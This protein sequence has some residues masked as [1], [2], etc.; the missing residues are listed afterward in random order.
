VDDSEFVAD[1]TV[2]DGTV[3]VPGA[4]FVKAWRLRNSGTCTW[5]TGYQFYDT[6]SGSPGTRISAPQSINIP[7]EVA[8]GETVD[9]S[10][11]MNAPGEEGEYTSQWRMANPG[12][13]AFGTQPYVSIVVREATGGCVEDSEFVTDVTVPDGTVFSPGETFTKTWRLKNGGTCTWS[14]DYQFYDIYSGSPGTRISA[15]GSINIPRQV[16]PGE[17]VDLSVEMTAPGE[18]G[19]YTSQW[20][21]AN[22][23]GGAFGTQPFVKIVVS[24]ES[25]EA[26]VDDSE[27][28]E[29]VTVPDG[30]EFSP[31]E[32]FTKTWRLR[33]DGTCTWTTAYMFYDIYSGVPETRISAPESINIP[34]EVAPGETVDLSVEMTAPDEPGEY[35]SP[36][37]LANPGGGAFGSQPYVKIVVTE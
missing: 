29:D 22:P 19:E 8:P 18:A 1:L 10:V 35:T 17:T 23:G 11:D 3:L 30:T 27:F 16:A 37:R 28:V 4:S 26:C 20:R 33:N 15:P 31:G 36:W 14:T 34:H 12:G 24:G 9:L 21:M 6:Y 5:T 25:E 7:R 32:T 2:P 13:G